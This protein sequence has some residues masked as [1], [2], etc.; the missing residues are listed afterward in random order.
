MFAS[1]VVG[2]IPRMGKT[3]SVRL[4]LLAAALDVR[5][6]LHLFEL[7]GTGDFGTL[8]PVAHAY[9]AGDEEDDI[10][11]AVTDMRALRAE[12]RRRTKVIRELPRAAVPREQ[13]HRRAGRLWP[14]WCAPTSVSGGS[15]TTATAKS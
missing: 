4:L 9:R 14:S 10:E 11:Y 13:G 5:A 3:F 1:M 12:M 7:K 6:E 2:S 15:S 8:E